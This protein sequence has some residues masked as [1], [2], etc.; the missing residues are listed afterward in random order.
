M[1]FIDDKF[2]QMVSEWNGKK[3]KVLNPG[4]EC[5]DVVAYFTDLLG[6]PDYPGNPTPFP[7]VPAYEIYTRFG[8]F[9][10]QYFDRIANGL[11]NTPV[12]GD[13]VVWGPNYNGGVGHV[14]VASGVGNVLSFQVFSQNDPL[15][16][17][18]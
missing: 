13:V 8:N 7:Y 11:T 18:C 2:N 12:E 6:M 15:G 1:S 3:L 17:V 16:G 14:A 10:Q 9:Q 5:F 4:G